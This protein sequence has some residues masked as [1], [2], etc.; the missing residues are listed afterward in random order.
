MSRTPVIVARSSASSHQPVLVTEAGD[1]L[2]RVGVVEERS[3]RGAIGERRVL[4]VGDAQSRW[5]RPVTGL[6]WYRRVQR[7]VAAFPTA[8]GAS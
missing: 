8:S 5:W 4:V 7:D 2:P 6:K 3:N 1:L